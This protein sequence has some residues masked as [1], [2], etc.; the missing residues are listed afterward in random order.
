[1]IINPKKQDLES[2]AQKSWVE[3]QIDNITPADIN[4]AAASHGNHVPATQTANN[5]V[6]L[7]ND[8]TWQTIT[9]TNIG[10]ATA[11]E[12]SQLKT[13]VSEGKALIAAA[14]TDKG[15]ET[16]A[17][18]SFA[19]MASNIGS[20][21]SGSSYAGTKAHSKTFEMMMGWYIMP[22]VFDSLQ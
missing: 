5:A 4:A 22:T 15:V 6:F 11:T 12:V 14:V 13:S 17:D 9:P 2:Y 20:I 19:T 7:R 21:K 10:A 18:A 16:A 1:M 8:N 3:D